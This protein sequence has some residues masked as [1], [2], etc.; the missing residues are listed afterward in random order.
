LAELS[1]G[2][3]DVR[4]DLVGHMT[5]TVM[6]HTMI[7]KKPIFKEGELSY[8]APRF[9]QRLDSFGGDYFFFLT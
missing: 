2:E 7:S 1:N 5:G 6:N 9:R 3:F 8:H 4:I